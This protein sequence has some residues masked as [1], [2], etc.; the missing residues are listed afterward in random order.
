MQCNADHTR[1]GVDELGDRGEKVH[2]S[3]PFPKSPSPKDPRKSAYDHRTRKTKMRLP[4]CP[5]Y[6]P[7][8][9]KAEPKRHTKA[10]H[11]SHKL[12]KVGTG[13]VDH[14]WHSAGEAA[15]HRQLEN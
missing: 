5:A 1:I 2:L 8:G 15:V 6:R 11:V 7:P 9:A 12:W 3:H 14:P 13:D 4:C 10:K